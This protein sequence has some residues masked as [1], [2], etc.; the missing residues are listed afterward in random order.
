MMDHACIDP[1]EMVQSKVSQYFHE[2]SSWSFLRL[3][4]CSTY[5]GIKLNESSIF[6]G[7]G[8]RDHRSAF[9]LKIWLPL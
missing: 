5:T 1:K 8:N 3:M 9:Y 6:C 7:E 4:S 2:V